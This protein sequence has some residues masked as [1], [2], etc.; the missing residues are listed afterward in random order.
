MIKLYYSPNSCSMSEHIVLEWLGIPYEAIQVQVG[1]DEYKKIAPKWA[2]PAMR[3]GGGELMTQNDALLKYLVKKYPEADL[4]S[5]G[6]IEWDYKLD[7]ALAM[8]GSDLHSSFGSIFVP[9]IYTTQ[10]DEISITAAKEASYA[11]I[12]RQMNY[13]NE[14]FSNNTYMLGAKRSVADAYAF[15]LLRWS[16]M[17]PKT[18]MEYPNLKRFFDLMMEDESVQKIVKIHNPEK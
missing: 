4:G 16:F 9:Q 17:I 6:T 3:D 15:T 11:R 7:N 8:I 12:E 13:L 14:H 5:D 2:V 1:W 18:V 10:T